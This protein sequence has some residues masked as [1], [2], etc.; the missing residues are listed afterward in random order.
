MAQVEITIRREKG[1]KQDAVSKLADQLAAQELRALEPWRKRFQQLEARKNQYIAME[2]QVLKRKAVELAKDKQLTEVENLLIF[3]TL[4]ATHEERTF[5]AALICCEKDED[6]MSQYNFN[7][8]HTK[9]EQFLSQ[10]GSVLTNFPFPLFP[11]DDDFDSINHKLPRECSVTGGA[12]NTQSRASMIF[13]APRN[14]NDV[15]GAGTLPLQ[16]NSQGG[17]EVDVSV[18]EKTFDDVFNSL[19][20]LSAKIDAAT[21]DKPDKSITSLTTAV[22]ELR[23]TVVSAHKASSAPQRRTSYKPVGP[24]RIRG[25]DNIEPYDATP[26]ASGF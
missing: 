24:R 5:V 25:G 19:R 2:N 6:R 1:R 20:Q 12:S 13:R 14:E 11:A 8:A 9:G 17:Y 10:Y 18:V 16:Q 4:Y 23:E 22:N 21:K 3:A 7:I 15:L 26:A